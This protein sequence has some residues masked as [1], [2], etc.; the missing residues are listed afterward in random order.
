M[1]AIFLPLIFGMMPWV[2]LNYATAL[3]PI[4][5]I[6]LASKAIFSG[7]VDWGPTALFYVS[8]AVLA[9]LGFMACTKFVG[10]ENVLFRI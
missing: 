5:N 8:L 10:R 3:V 4:L 6:S 2:K 1:A 9:S 7:K